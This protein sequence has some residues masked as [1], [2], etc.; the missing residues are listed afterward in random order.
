[1]TIWFCFHFAS[2]ICSPVTGRSTSVARPVLGVLLIACLSACSHAPPLAPGAE[3]IDVEETVIARDIVRRIKDISSRRYPQGVVKRFNQAKTTA[4]VKAEFEVLD[5]LPAELSQGLFAQPG[6]YDAVVRF[7]N[8]SSDDDRDKD[9][10][11][12]SIKVF[13]VPGEVILGDSGVQ[14]FVLNSEPA[15]FVATPREFLQFVEASES[16]SPWRFFIRPSNFSS[17]I[18]VLRGRKA[19]ASPLD[20]PFWSTTPYRFGQDNAVAV[21]YSAKPCSQVT[22]TLADDLSADHLSEAVAAHLRR[23]PACFD[24]AVQ[25]QAD[26]VQ[27]P[28]EDASVVWDERVQPFRNVG[29]IVVNDQAVI[30]EEALARCESMAFNPWHA[31]PEHRPLGGINRVRREVYEEMARFRQSARNTQ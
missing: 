27:M 25:F 30:S 8:A 26:P 29:R 20:I 19:I 17:L 18:A 1:M 16:G 24:F 6:R 9:V 11:G 3:R 28:I 4:C 13:A 7:A 23:A 31:L 14:D 5:G 2:R 10:R 22:T 15:L 21:K 12:M